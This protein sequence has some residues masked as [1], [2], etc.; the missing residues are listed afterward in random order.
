LRE[1]NQTDERLREE[2][3]AWDERL[4]EENQTDERFLGQK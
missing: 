1:E 4:R 3:L 2:K